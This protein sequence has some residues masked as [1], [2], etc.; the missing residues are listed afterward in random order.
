MNETA[1]AIIRLAVMAIFAVNAILTANGRNP[2]PFDETAF[3]EAVTY[4][5]AG[6]SALWGWWKNNNVTKEAQAAQKYKEDAKIDGL[7]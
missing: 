1:K 4:V 3:T 7:E 6:L 5:V 2:I